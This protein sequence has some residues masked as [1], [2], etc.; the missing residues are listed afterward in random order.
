MMKRLSVALFALLFDRYIFGTIPGVWSLLG[1]GLIL[2]SAVFVAVHKGVVAGG[3]RA[4]AQA[5]VGLLRDEE[6]AMLGDVEAF[7]EEGGDEEDLPL[8]EINVTH[9]DEAEDLR[10]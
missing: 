3:R 7:G 2:G 10:I 6:R 9:H 1:S 8:M 4:G 5:E